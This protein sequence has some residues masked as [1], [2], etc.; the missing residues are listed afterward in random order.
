[1]P[2][3]SD[4]MS[5]IDKEALGLK[6]VDAASL[7]I[8]LRTKVELEA[9]RAIAHNALSDM[10]AVVA[11]LNAPAV[12]DV[13]SSMSVE[14]HVLRATLGIES[15]KAA[16]APRPRFDE[17]LLMLNRVNGF[18]NW[19]VAQDF[20]RSIPYHSIESQLLVGSQI[21]NFINSYETAIGSSLKSFDTLANTI[22]QFKD[23]LHMAGIPREP[24]RE[25]YLKAIEAISGNFFARSDLMYESVRR[26]TENQNN[27]LMK[28]AQLAEQALM[29]NI[30]PNASAILG[31]SLTFPAELM[32]SA[33]DP[34]MREWASLVYEARVVSIDISH[35]EG[36]LLYAE[37]ERETVIELLA[38]RLALEESQPE[39]SI[40]SS[41]SLEQPDTLF[42]CSDNHDDYHAQYYGET[43]LTSPDDSSKKMLSQ[44]LDE[45]RQKEAFTEEE[46]EQIEDEA[47]QAEIFV[48]E[49]FA[50]MMHIAFLFLMEISILYI[51]EG[52]IPAEQFRARQDK[53]LARFR[54]RLPKPEDGRPR[55]TGLFKDEYDFKKALKEV[56]EKFGK[57]PSQIQVLRAIR[58][59]PLCQKPLKDLSEIKEAK[60]LRNWLDRCG[61]T[62]EEALQR[63]WKPAKSGK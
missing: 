11:K 3:I 5:K 20:A 2:K 15:L 22:A 63:Y 54:E 1:M 50:D 44:Y 36:H 53:A 60:T 33:V 47:R 42:E 9:A 34:L 4:L 46:W 17:M 56:L 43:H 51:K 29:K 23:T 6:T 62:Y 59:H 16:S 30:L 37:Y 8:G 7:G 58:Q 31:Q 45:L 12:Y 49:N 39:A 28:T 19:I 24:F 55:G 52:P 40:N 38:A 41:G 48:R 21:K 32:R 14:K 61:M 57:R 26:I 18:N 27:Y 10:S 13:F 35:D 25:S